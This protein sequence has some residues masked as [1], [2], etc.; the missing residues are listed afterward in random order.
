MTTV[1]KLQV[2][3]DICIQA[4]GIAGHVLKGLGSDGLARLDN[5]LDLSTR[6]DEAISEVLIKFFLS[7]EVPAVLLSEESGLIPLMEK[8]QYTIAVDELDGTNN[9]YRG[10]GFLP[11]CTVITIFDSLT[12]KFQDACVAII[13]EHVSGSIWYA[14]RGKGLYLN[15]KKVQNL[16][17]EKK[18]P[19]IIVDSYGACEESVAIL[20]RLPHHAFVRCY[21]SAALH[22]AGV[23]SG[24]FDA[25]I[26]SGQKAHE[27]GAGYLLIQEVGGFIG[28]LPYGKTIDHE[29]YLFDAIYPTVAAISEEVISCIL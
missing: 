4:V 25:Y 3:C 6:A 17:S 20:G 13:R 26:A 29:P 12:P 18:N 7:Q 16:V 27:L 23:A 11:Y 14:C 24:M 5:S 9:Y 10:A 15:N 22:L 8:P 28:S 2:L 1:S 19:H 21:G